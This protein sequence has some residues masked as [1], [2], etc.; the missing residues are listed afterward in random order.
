[1][2]LTWLLNLVY[3]SPFTQTVEGH[4][5]TNELKAQYDYSPRVPGFS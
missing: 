5:K 4:L 2:V 3:L 1:M